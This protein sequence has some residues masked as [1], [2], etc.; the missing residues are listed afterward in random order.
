MNNPDAFQAGAILGFVAGTLSM[1]AVN[2]FGLLAMIALN[3]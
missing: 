3:A 2:S 1:F